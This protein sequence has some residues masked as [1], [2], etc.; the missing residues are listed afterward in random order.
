MSWSQEQ[1]ENMTLRWP[2][3][4]VSACL[5]RCV[6]QHAG[7][8]SPP[9][10]NATEKMVWIA[11]ADLQCSPLAPILIRHQGPIC[12]PLEVPLILKAH[13]EFR[14]HFCQPNSPWVWAAQTTLPPRPVE[15]GGVGNG[16]DFQ[17]HLC[18]LSQVLGFLSEAVDEADLR[19]ENDID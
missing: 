1:E 8:I 12:N 9:C 19:N 4:G 15:Q 11:W 18:L 7:N 14:T 2:G 13:T 3:I 6:P 10:V 5:Q 16:A 17:A